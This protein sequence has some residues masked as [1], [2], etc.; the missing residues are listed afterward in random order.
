M[1]VN[2]GGAKSPWMGALV[3][4][5]SI[6][7]VSVFAVARDWGWESWLWA[8]GVCVVGGAFSSLAQAERNWRIDRSVAQARVLDSRA[9]AEPGLR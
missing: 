4:A 5:G 7:G 6:A 8:A 3:A 2:I 1:A 9:D